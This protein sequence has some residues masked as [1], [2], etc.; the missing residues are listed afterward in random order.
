[1]PTLLE[2]VNGKDYFTANRTIGK[3]LGNN[4]AI[5]LNEL[6]DKYDYFS[7]NNSLVS[8]DGHEGWFYL[9]NQKVTERTNLSRYQQQSC[10][11]KLIH[12]QIIKY[13]ICPYT[14]Q[15]YFY[16]DKSYLCVLLA[17]D[18]K[19]DRL[20][21]KSQGDVSSLSGGCKFVKGGGV[22]SSHPIM[23]KE[24]RSMNPDDESK[25]DNV[26]HAAPQ[27][28]YKTLDPVKRYRLDEQQA[29]TL[30][31][32]KDRCLQVDDGTLCHWAKTYSLERLMDVHRETCRR[33]PKNFAGYMNNLLMSDAIVRTPD[34][35][36]CAK[37]A[38]EFKAA[39]NWV[40]LKIGSKYVTFDFGRSKEEISL[41]QKPETFARQLMEKYK[42]LQTNRY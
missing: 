33:R 27:K 7:E 24:S 12:E 1:M 35:E 21:Q 26:S 29:E 30:K 41:K 25:K 11:K 17:K 39:N 10:I 32:L 23:D 20:F 13:L 8:K 5:F 37:F 38:E 16:I 42:I 36:E 9:S 28:K 22:S 31:W 4:V 2:T 6:L 40:A 15:R 34:A 3:I 19:R 18:E 14:S